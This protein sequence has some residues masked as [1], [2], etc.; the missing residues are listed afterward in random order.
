M[1]IINKKQ[2]SFR[3]NHST[4]MALLIMLKYIRNAFDN[5]EYAVG[6]FLDFQKAFDNVDHNI[7]PICSIG[8]LKYT[9]VCYSS[10]AQCQIKHGDH[11]H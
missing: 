1:E 9:H 8:S 2:F 11:W 5:G 7:N 4:Y 3:N 10:T 6:I